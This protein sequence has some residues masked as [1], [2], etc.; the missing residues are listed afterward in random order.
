MTNFSFWHNIFSTLFIK[1]CDPFKRISIFCAQ[2]F[3]KS[4]SYRYD[5]CG[6]ELKQCENTQIII[7]TILANLLIVN[8]LN[9]YNCNHRNLAY[10]NLRFWKMISSKV[11][12]WKSKEQ[13]WRISWY[14]YVDHV[15]LTL[16]QNLGST[17]ELL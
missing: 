3:S 10:Q 7:I 14:N 11:L 17:V 8:I 13:N 5:V 1:L 2:L 16:R 15:P 9:T 6:K 12:M 4:G